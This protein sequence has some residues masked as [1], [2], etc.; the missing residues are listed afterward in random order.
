[1][2]GLPP[3]RQAELDALMTQ[4]ARLNSEQTTHADALSV[5]LAMLDFTSAASFA[6]CWRVLAS[7]HEEIAARYQMLARVAR[8]AADVAVS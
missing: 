5:E 4:F 8:L 7:H 3:T 1:M 2:R 6:A